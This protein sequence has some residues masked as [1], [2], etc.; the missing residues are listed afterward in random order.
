[1]KLVKKGLEP[2][3]IVQRIPLEFDSIEMFSLRG[4]R[5]RHWEE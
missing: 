5:P 1:M 4:V 3:S 2:H